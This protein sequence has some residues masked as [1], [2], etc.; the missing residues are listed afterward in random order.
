VEVEGMIDCTTPM[1]YEQ[2]YAQ[3]KKVCARAQ[4]TTGKTNLESFGGLFAVGQAQYMQ[5]FL[6]SVIK[7]D[8]CPETKY[9]GKSRQTRERNL[10]FSSCQ[11]AG[12]EP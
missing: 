5:K 4:E 2:L 3:L 11:P 7:L 9:L 8:S 12:R 1:E 10:P 6:F